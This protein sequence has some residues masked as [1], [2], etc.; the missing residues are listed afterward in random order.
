[1]KANRSG[2][3]LL[4]GESLVFSPLA[5]AVRARRGRAAGQTDLAR[6]L[7]HGLWWTGLAFFVVPLFVIYFAVALQQHG[8][9]LLVVLLV[10]LS[11]PLQIHLL[12]HGI[13]ALELATKSQVAPGSLGVPKWYQRWVHAVLSDQPGARPPHA[14][15]L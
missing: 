13:A 4:L 10:S 7:L 15:R 12:W 5:I 6:R 8:M 1:M 2:D 3:W 11:A 9:V 14:E